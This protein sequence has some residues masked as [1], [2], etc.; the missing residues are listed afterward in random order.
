MAVSLR[1]RRCFSAADCPNLYNPP[2]Q[3][4][5]F[6]RIGLTHCRSAAGKAG[7]LQRLVSLQQPTALSVL[8]IARARDTTDALATS[9]GAA[10]RNLQVPIATQ[11]RR[12]SG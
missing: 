10:Y 5:S 6:Y 1:N 12:R 7:R 3:K 11:A 4:F 8:T 2:Y 9:M